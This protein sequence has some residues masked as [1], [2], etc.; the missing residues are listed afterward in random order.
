MYAT[1]LYCHSRLGR[2]DRLPRFPV[3]KRLA[4]DTAKGRLW[5]VCRACGKWNLSPLEE[6]WDAFDECE[7]LFRATH[8]RVSTDNIGL[9]E[10]PDGMSLIRIGKP[11][12]PEF[13]AWRYTS[14][15]RTRRLKASAALGV[16]AGG[17]AGIALGAVAMGFG[18]LAFAG[19][20]AT[21]LW[22]ADEGPKRRP[23]TTFRV[24]RQLVHLSQEDAEA[25]RVFDD[26]APDRFGLSLHHSKGVELLRGAEARRV[27]ARVIP[28]LN[29][30]GGT[31]QEVE[32]AIELVDSMGSAERCVT[33]TVHRV[34]R[35]G[36]FVTE[37]PKELRLALEMSL[38]EEGERRALEYELAQLERA[39]R[40]AEEIAEIA[41]NL[42]IPGD[43]LETITGLRRARSTRRPAFMFG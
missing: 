22:V 19:A 1:C 10:L 9:V 17:M 4:F 43:V 16:A 40:E 35:W 14:R 20:Y 36:G 26:G 5:V 13:A 27:L 41:D 25:T 42:L 29:P 8:V 33:E 11:L 34:K 12:W 30:M 39:W 21:G 3:G 38:Q 18:A 7:R 31:Q 6:R 24:N 28:A 2:N 37:L 23:A 15:F 32:G